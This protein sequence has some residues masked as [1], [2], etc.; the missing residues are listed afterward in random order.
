M[1]KSTRDATTAQMNA[2][3]SPQWRLGK[4]YYRDGPEL[5]QDSHQQQHIYDAVRQQNRIN[6]RLGVGPS[7]MTQTPY[8]PH[9]GH[10]AVPQAWHGN[11]WTEAQYLPYVQMGNAQFEH[12]WNSPRPDVSPGNGGQWAGGWLSPSTM[13][14]APMNGQTTPPSPVMGSG[15]AGHGSTTPEIPQATQ[16]AARRE[17]VLFYLAQQRSE[18]SLISDKIAPR[19][20]SA[21]GN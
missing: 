17:R 19:R 12:R 3:R 6:S 5:P 11:R 16:G 14:S 9:N 7:Q 2:P 10:L 13:N 4:P 1:D 8:N 20:Q 21:S 18:R 15:Y